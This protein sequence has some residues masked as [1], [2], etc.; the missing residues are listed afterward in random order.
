[1]NAT[2]AGPA[3]KKAEPCNPFR[4]IPGVVKRPDAGTDFCRV[5]ILRIDHTSPS[6]NPFMLLYSKC[7]RVP[8]TKIEDL[9]LSMVMG[10]RDR[11]FFLCRVEGN[12]LV[13]MQEF[14]KGEWDK[15]A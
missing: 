6:K 11:M 9:T 15:S 4:I 5:K 1:M 13:L 7:G 3:I 14:S 2:A 10:S 8:L 12:D